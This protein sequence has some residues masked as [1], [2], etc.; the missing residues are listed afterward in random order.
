VLVQ[1]VSV[2][3]ASAIKLF[4]SLLEARKTNGVQQHPN[5]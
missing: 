2:N 1:G 5:F 3:N 4:A